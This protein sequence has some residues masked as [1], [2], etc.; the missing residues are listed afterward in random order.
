MNQNWLCSH[1]ICEEDFGL[2]SPSRKSATPHNDRKEEQYRKS[3][4]DWFKDEIDV[5]SRKHS[6]Q[7]ATN[8]NETTQ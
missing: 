8:E 7:R 6:P 1:E 3:N 2:H 4:E 5:Y